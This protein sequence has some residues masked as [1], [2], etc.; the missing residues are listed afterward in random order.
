MHKEKNDHVLKTLLP[1]LSFVNKHGKKNLDHA[2]N[3]PKLSRFGNLMAM[4]TA[5]SIR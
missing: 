2:M 3:N 1:K 5:M 4:V